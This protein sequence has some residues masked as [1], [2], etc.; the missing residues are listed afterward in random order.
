MD[1]LVQLEKMYD[2]ELIKRN[3]NYNIKNQLEKSIDNSIDSI[4]AKAL[5]SSKE[6]VSKMHKSIDDI[7]SAYILNAENIINQLQ[8]LLEVCRSN[9]NSINSLIGLRILEF[10]GI[11]QNKKT[12]NTS[13]T[14]SVI[15]LWVGRFRTLLYTFL[16]LTTLR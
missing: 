8:T 12:I 14:S 2:E 6:S 5:A 16:L 4:Q 13:N 11:K 1:G 10:A 3:I 15:I 7:L 9:E